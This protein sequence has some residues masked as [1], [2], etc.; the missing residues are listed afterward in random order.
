MK[1]NVIEFKKDVLDYIIKDFPFEKYKIKYKIRISYNFLRS[2][3]HILIIKYKKK[4]FP[5]YDEI[6]QHFTYFN[7]AFEDNF[8]NDDKDLGYYK[9][10][11]ENPDCL[12]TLVKYFV[13]IKEEEIIKAQE[14][15]EIGIVPT[16]WKFYTILK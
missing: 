6:V 12:E 8:S 15:A 3:D 4:G 1:E 13:Q 16:K 10:I 11:K 2:D 14:N 7:F 9:Y 5:F